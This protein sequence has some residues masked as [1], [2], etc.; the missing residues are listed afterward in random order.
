MRLYQL[1]LGGYNETRTL[2]L[3]FRA[4]PHRAVWDQF[5]QYRDMIV[6]SWDQKL[7]LVSNPDWF[8]DT[9]V[10]WPNSATFINQCF[11]A[12]GNLESFDKETQDEK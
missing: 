5:T 3:S 1:W 8:P 12:K 4:T 2:V 10:G 6:A 11:R 9:P 7:R